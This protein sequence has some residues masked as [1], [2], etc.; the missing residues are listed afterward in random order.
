[1]KKLF[2]IVLLL[3]FICAHAQDPANENIIPDSYE[4]VQ[5]GKNINT[6]YHESAP[7]VSPDGN[8][9]YFFVSN[10]PENY[11]GKTGSQDIWHAERDST[12]NWGTAKHMKSPLNNR[13]YNQVFTVS[14]DGNT[15]LIR[16]GNGKDTEGFSLTHKVKDSWS[17]PK[18]LK[19]EGYDEMRKGVYSGGSMS[20]D[21]KVLLMYFS[22]RSKS[23]LSDLYVSFKQENGDWSRP[24][25]LGTNINTHLDEFGPFLAQDDRTM[26][27]A[28]SRAGGLGGM[29]IYKTERL[30]N[31][32]LKWSDPKNLGAPVNTSGFDAYFSVDE[33]GIN[34]F[35]TRAYMS[36]DGGSLDILGLQ[37]IKPVIKPKKLLSFDGY[38]FDEKSKTPVKATIE[39]K[40][41]NYSDDNLGSDPETGYFS[42]EISKYGLYKFKVSAEG[43]MGAMD[44]L[45]IQ[46]KNIDQFITHNFYL[47][48]LKV[49]T[50]VRLNNIFFDFD[51]A[52]LRPESFTELNMVVDLLKK[53]EHLEIEIGGHTDNMGS[54]DYN[55]KLSDARAKA[56]RKYL[57][58]EWIDESRVSAKGYGKSKPEVGNET[59]EG[60]QINRRVE[61]IILKN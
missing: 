61:F 19:I 49:G 5:L 55:V 9:L 56:V 27:F 17:K 60:R 10:H 57:V 2:L 8:T 7:I 3:N 33:T 23:L 29:D 43:Y 15:L 32:W 31:T 20:S 46:E 22:E 35:T 42:T 53:N 44:S 12:G 36:L 34:A 54:E 38:V 40:V 41:E 1:M 21:G 58:Q 51:K 47:K 24:K 59:D 48:P 13:R 39:Y 52:V 26:Y 37:P 30:D 16:G 4:L 6:P 45:L 14:P 50:A 28:S 25:K 18:P 11:L